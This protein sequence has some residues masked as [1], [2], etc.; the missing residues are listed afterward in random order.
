MWRVV[1]KGQTPPNSVVTRLG[2]AGALE[3]WPPRIRIAF[4]TDAETRARIRA[5]QKRAWLSDAELCMILVGTLEA[6]VA[7]NGNDE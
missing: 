6:L 1:E 3:G 5:A 7:E 4:D 2:R